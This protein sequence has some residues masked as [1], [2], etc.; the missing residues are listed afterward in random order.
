MQANDTE[1]TGAAALYAALARAIGK[2]QAVEKDSNNSFHKYKYASAEALLEEGRGALAAEGLCVFPLAWFAVPRDTGEQHQ[3][4]AG[5]YAD[6]KVKYRLAHASGAFVDC[7]A[8]TPVISEKGRPEDKAVATALTCSLGYFVRGLLLLPRV[9][10]G[11]DVDR[12][13]DREY[14]PRNNPRQGQP[15][16]GGRSESP[17]ASA[18]KAQAPADT[19]P[20]L[21]AE[22]APLVDAK[23]LARVGRPVAEW[24]VDDVEAAMSFLLGACATPADCDSVLGPWGRTLNKHARPGSKAHALFAGFNSVFNKRRAEL[25]KGKAA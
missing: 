23:L 17:P 12:R 8:E 4:P 7:E 24:V 19:W 14:Q 13:D 5:Y 22:L 25:A 21:I 10:E 6:L 1:P 9:D 3:G 15:Q 20:A 11:H 16:G 18:P 2:A